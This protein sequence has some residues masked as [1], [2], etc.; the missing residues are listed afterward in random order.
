MS[1]QVGG[2]PVDTGIFDHL[3]D[4]RIGEGGDSVLGG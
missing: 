1:E 2:E 3:T 4:S